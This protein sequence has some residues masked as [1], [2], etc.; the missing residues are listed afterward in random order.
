M[1]LSIEEQATIQALRITMAAL[2]DEFTPRASRMASLGLTEFTVPAGEG[3]TATIGIK[4]VNWKQPS[5]RI[6]PIMAICL[7]ECPIAVLSKRHM[8]GL[9]TVDSTLADSLVVVTEFMKSPTEFFK[10][11]DKAMHD[12]ET[13]LINTKLEL[14][15]LFDADN[16][17]QNMVVWRDLT[18]GELRDWLTTNAAPGSAL[19]DQSVHCMDFTDAD[20]A[21]SPKSINGLVMDADGQLVL[22]P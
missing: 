9:T 21:I 11:F 22:L 2:G 8:P 13:M 5:G 14:D 18:Y 15:K 1:T 6:L 19:S 7:N 17:P 4:N 12:A 20:Q 3:T 10:D 16:G